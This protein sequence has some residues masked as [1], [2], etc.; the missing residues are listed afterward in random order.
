MNFQRRRKTPGTESERASCDASASSTEG[1][2]TR[3]CAAGASAGSSVFMCSTRGTNRVPRYPVSGPLH[4][5]SSLSL[6]AAATQPASVTRAP[7][8][9]G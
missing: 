9:A 1:G 3:G 6:R 8:P 2:S 7:S 4:P 5:S